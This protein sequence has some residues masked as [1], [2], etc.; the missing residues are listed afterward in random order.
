MHSDAEREM[1]ELLVSD[2][3]TE[4]ERKELVLWGNTEGLSQIPAG[5]FSLQTDC[6]QRKV[7]TSTLCV[8]ADGWHEH[9]GQD[10]LE[11]MLHDCWRVMEMHLKHRT[12]LPCS[13]SSDEVHVF[14]S[15]NT[16]H[17]GLQC[18]WWGNPAVP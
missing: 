17:D 12:S 6:V 3:V 5:D 13:S 9:P 8:G 1:T 11:F 18:W 10:A 15:K 7:P 14:C 16:H 4:R 2:L